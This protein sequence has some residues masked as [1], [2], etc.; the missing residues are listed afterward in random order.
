V[1]NVREYDPLDPIECLE[2]H[3][4]KVVFKNYNGNKRPVI[5]FLNFFI[6]NAK[7][8][9]EMEIGF[10]NHHNDK[11]IRNQHRQ[12]Q[13]KNRASRDAQIEL[14]ED[15]LEDFLHPSHTHDFSMADPFDRPC[16][17]F[18]LF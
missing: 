6:L 14:K 1:N 2:L 11:W 3:L 12:L 18:L 4:K 7:V 13:V 5:D 17:P 9:E 15:Q 16:G 10:L 8:L